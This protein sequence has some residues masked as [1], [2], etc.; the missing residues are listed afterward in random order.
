MCSSGSCEWQ[1]FLPPPHEPGTSDIQHRTPDIE[2]ISPGT[3]RLLTPALSSISEEREE[4]RAVIRV[5]VFNARIDQDILT[6]SLSLEER[7]KL[8]LAAGN[9]P[10][11]GL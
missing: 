7:V 6:P 3:L 5:Q 2:G 1:R 11:C 4:A 9:S 10:I 8:G